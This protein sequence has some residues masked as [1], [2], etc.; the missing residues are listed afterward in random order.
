MEWV[1]AN[2]HVLLKINHTEYSCRLQ[3]F[4]TIPRFAVSLS[5]VVCL[6]TSIN[7]GE[8]QPKSHVCKVYKRNLFN[9]K[10]VWWCLFQRIPG[11]I[12]ETDTKNQVMFM[13]S[14]T[15]PNLVIIETPQHFAL[16][17][18]IKRTNLDI[19]DTACLHE[20]HMLQHQTSC[21]TTKSTQNTIV[22][23]PKANIS[24]LL[25][26]KYG[27][28]TTRSTRRHYKANEDIR[29]FETENVWALR[30]YPKL[31]S[32]TRLAAE[33]WWEMHFGRNNER[34]KWIEDYV[35]TDTVVAWKHVEDVET[36]I[37]QEHEDMRNA[38][39]LE[40]TTRKL[41]KTFEEILNDIR[42]AQNDL[43]SS[44]DENDGEDEEDDDE[45]TELGKLCKDDEPCWVMG[46][47]SKTVQQCMESF[48]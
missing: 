9:G 33:K 1:T 47:I 35:D 37:K 10:D 21:P 18:L 29:C 32:K 26:G 28:L 15:F 12:H 23:T 16:F 17:K 7:T 20:V 30:Q 43:A 11:I 6:F 36:V 45:H 39:T 25:E 5:N 41:K 44:N 24:P 13:V 31:R 22:N 48:Q 46:T 42:N 40:L 8:Q 38:E 27:K 19:K 4:P 2:L 14:I 3:G 34:E